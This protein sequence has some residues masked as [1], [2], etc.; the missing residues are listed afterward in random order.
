MLP[1]LRIWH[2][3]GSGTDEQQANLKKLQTRLATL[4]NAEQILRDAK[5]RFLAGLR[6]AGAGA[7]S[8]YIWNINTARVKYVFIRFT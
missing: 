3:G 4:K 1:I 6:R 5:D 2:P 7:K 8:K